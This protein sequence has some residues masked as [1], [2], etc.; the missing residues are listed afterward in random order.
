MLC[1]MTNA[2]N[3]DHRIDDALD[4]ALRRD[5]PLMTD[6]AI[7]ALDGEPAAATL[8]VAAHEGVLV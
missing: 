7:A 4:W 6:T 2:T 5:D 8:L 1:A 3:P